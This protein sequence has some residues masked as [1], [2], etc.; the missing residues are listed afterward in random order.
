MPRFAT[1]AAVFA[2]AA[3]TTALAQDVVTCPPLP[4]STGICTGLAQ[5]LNDAGFDTALAVQNPTNENT[6][7]GPG[8]IA[9][10]FKF[11]ADRGQYS[12]CF[13]Y[14]LEADLD[15]ALVATIRSGSATNADREA[16]AIDAII[17]NGVIVFNDAA[18]TEGE[19]AI[20][21]ITTTAPSSIIFWIVPD[22]RMNDF[23]TNPS[24][25]AYTGG[26]EPVP[27][28]SLSQANPGGFDQLV[29]YAQDS[30]RE[31][32]FS[33]EDIRRTQGS[34]GDFNDLV[35]TV[36]AVFFPLIADCPVVCEP[37]STAYPYAPF[38][39]VGVV[40]EE[41]TATA[42]SGEGKNCVCLEFDV[43]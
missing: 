14:A 31:T 42:S 30:I 25:F 37:I 20:S 39:G 41:F 23:Q 36:D 4:A 19:T 35:F 10:L 17:D 40:Q 28:F 7:P 9:L 8:D 1:V 21:T 34:D 27:L 16:F 43:K 18:D 3:A 12:F 22:E 38:P 2:V 29:S 15:Q 5:N 33:W 11:I 24:A 13:G 32:V 6:L 26:S